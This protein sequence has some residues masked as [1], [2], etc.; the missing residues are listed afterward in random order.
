MSNK[1]DV[2][3]CPHCGQPMPVFGDAPKKM[4]F[5]TWIKTLNGRDA[6][7]PSNSI[8]KYAELVGIPDEFIHLAWS[9]F[10]D[11]HAGKGKKYTDWLR[12]FRNA[13]ESNWYRLWYMADG[14]FHLTTAGVQ[15]KRM[16]E[17]R[18]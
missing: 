16:M 5:D 3:L 10:S 4:T 17:T 12:A 7:E 8:W 13:V 15:R 2:P 14:R 11:G 1:K 18:R 6:I 9:A